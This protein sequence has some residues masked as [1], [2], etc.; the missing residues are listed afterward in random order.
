MKI[1]MSIFAAAALLSA[2]AL[3]QETAAQTPQAFTNMAASSNMFEIMS[4]KAALEK[5]TSAEAKAFAEHMVADHTKA[6]EEM[7]PAA[8]AEG[9]TVPD[10]LDE[11]HQAQLDKL[12]PLEGEN[13]D[14]AYIAAQ[15]AAHEEAVALFKGYAAGGAPG[16]MKEFA[17]KTLPTLE[18]HLAEVQKLKQ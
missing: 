13:F 4:S 16:T 8:E 12:T 7:K 6:G 17:A 15:L 10:R 5:A 9:V 14:Q 18:E 2:P 1:F 3:A 11:K